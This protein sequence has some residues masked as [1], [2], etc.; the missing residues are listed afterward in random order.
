MKEFRAIKSLELRAGGNG[1]PV[2]RGYAAVWDSPSADLG[3]FREV[4]RRGAFR[5]SLASSADVLALGH[6]NTGQV[7]ARRSAGTLTLLEDQN[8]LA[9]EITLKARTSHAL[10][11]V[12]DVRAG[13]IAGMSIGFKT[14]REGKSKM[15]DGTLLRELLEL[16]LFEVSP[17]AFPA[18]PDT[19][20]ALRSLGFADGRSSGVHIA[21]ADDVKQRLR[22]AMMR[23]RLCGMGL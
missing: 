21:D 13:N 1:V 15:A 5:R 4:V 22:L 18:Y 12:E 11:I 14:A 19:S 20:I 3:G 7:L 10:G 6:H 9:V 23:L 8:G 17:V 2:L 16:T